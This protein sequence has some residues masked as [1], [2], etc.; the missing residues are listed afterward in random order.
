M[1]S[2]LRHAFRQLVKSPGFALAAILTLALGIGIS[3]TIFNSVN[4]LLFR[5]LPFRDPDTLVYLNERNLKQGL[6]QMNVSYAD[7]IHWKNENHVFDGMG[8]WDT[9][10]LTLGSEDGP[11]RINGCVVS[12]GLFSM[13]GIKPALGRDFRADEEQPGSE[14]VVILSDALWRRRFAANP[15]VIGQSI[16]LNGKTYAVVGVM[17]S[18]V[19]FP[20]NSD[21][22]VP[23]AIAQPEKRHGEFSYDCAARLKPGITLSQASADLEQIHKAT[24]IE[25]PATNANI[26]G[27]VR[28]LTDVFLGRDLQTMG[29]IMLGAV[30]FV[31]AVASAN[32]ASLL[33]T[34]SLDRQK[35]FAVRRALGASSWRLV[36]QLLVE[37]LLLGALG[38]GLGFLFSQWGHGSLRSLAKVEIPYWLDFSID[39]R[40]VGFAIG[41]S[42]FT[43]VLFGLAPAWQVIRQNVQV[44]LTESAR[45]SSGGHCRQRLRSLL[46]V[47]QIASA[48]LL[49]CGTG[50]MIR[51]LL[52]LQQVDPGFDPMRLAK[53]SINFQSNPK[54]TREMKAAFFPALMERLR[55]LPGIESAAA[56]SRLPMAGGTTTQAFAIEG[57]VPLTSSARPIGN[58]R[59]I[60][61][62]YFSTMRIPLLNGRDFAETDTS[63]STKVIIVDSAF[64]KQHFGDINPIGEHIFWDPNDPSTRREIIGVAADTKQT[65]LDQNS[66]PGFYVPFTQSSRSRMDVVYRSSM[67]DPLTQLPAIRQILREIDP[68]L[69]L[70]EPITMTSLI[71]DSYWIRLFLG[72][73]LVGF[74]V[75]AMALAALGVG[76]VVTFSVIQRTRE[77]GIRM[78]L[79]A[80]SKDVLHLILTHGMR[81]VFLGLVAGMLGSLGLS[82]F[83]ASQLFG[84]STFDPLTLALSFFIFASVSLFA[85]WLPARR[86]TRVNPIEALRAE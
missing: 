33:L 80:T 74:S 54:S 83:L 15:G 10:D 62:N 36:R 19:R 43:S 58:L 55:G 20:N 61:P 38:G 84:V 44:G 45:G 69:P 49:L 22:W 46:V 40:V 81:L 1:L 60:T 70:Y 65:G 21:L 8:V 29:W 50:L 6:T 48:T 57:R 31:L 14:A 52:K 75:L 76:S 4:P 67:R 72:R 73:L 64:A 23:I 30:A 68:L 78:A 39:T 2:D 77:I 66:R 37:S 86:A 51:S 12:A 17:P 41:V 25:S 16:A 63:E 24:A 11:E 47:A 32:V 5:A 53:F 9:N 27:L 71:G 82:R 7:F 42:I 34:Q 28:P 56:S 85:C 3:T 13:L 18:R 59:V 79:G 26:S 35:E